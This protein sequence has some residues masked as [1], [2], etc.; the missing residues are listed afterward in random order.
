MID[1]INESGLEPLM[2]QAEAD[3][4]SVKDKDD[5]GGNPD[6]GRNLTT[7]MRARFTVAL[8]ALSNTVKHVADIDKLLVKGNVY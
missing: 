3:N 5:A 6:D 7:D 8:E 1:E 2:K 4:K